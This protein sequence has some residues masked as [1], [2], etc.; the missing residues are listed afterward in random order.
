MHLHGHDLPE[1]RVLPGQPQGVHR[2]RGR[3]LSHGL[4]RV[5]WQWPLLP[6]GP[7]LRGDLWAGVLRL[8]GGGDARGVL[9]RI[10]VDPQGA[11]V[12]RSVVP[13]P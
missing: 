11:A 9:R 3:V 1:R 2:R 7:H 5:L 8:S 6:R 4:S 10:R 12:Q 13:A